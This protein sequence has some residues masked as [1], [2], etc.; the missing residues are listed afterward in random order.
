MSDLESY[1]F[2]E[3]V[4]HAE[5]ARQE[6]MEV[7]LRFEDIATWLAHVQLHLDRIEKAAADLT[8]SRRR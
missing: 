5:A 2:R 4:Y 7:E 1:V 3:P 8:R 6:L